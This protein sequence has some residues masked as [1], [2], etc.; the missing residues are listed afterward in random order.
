MQLHELIRE[1]DIKI[2]EH[3]PAD[4]IELL[5]EL[6]GWCTDKSDLEKSKSIIWETLIER[7]KSMSTGIGLGVAIP[8]C[9][10]KHVSEIH[11]ILAL[12]KEGIDFQAVD[13]QPVRI[14]VLLLMP[15]DKFDKHIKTLATIARLF[16]NEGFR[17]KILKVS[18]SLEAHELLKQESGNSNI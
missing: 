6:L 15:K 11:G 16:N 10:T 9:S 17:E 4:K 2:Y 3:P 8:H 7:E 18:T 14:I 12:L 13:E 5:R 1:S